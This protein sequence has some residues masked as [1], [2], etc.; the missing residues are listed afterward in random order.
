MASSKGSAVA[1]VGV[2]VYSQAAYDATFTTTATFS[3]MDSL[4]IQ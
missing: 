2:V 1:L 4:R 3:P